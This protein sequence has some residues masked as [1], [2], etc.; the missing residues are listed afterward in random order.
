MYP[1]FISCLVCKPA[2][3]IQVAFGPGD[4]PS[5]QIKRYGSAKDG[6]GGK[7]S[8]S[9]PK[10]SDYGQNLLSLPSAANE[11]GREV[12]SA[13]SS[14]K[15]AQ[16]GKKEYREP[17]VRNLSLSVSLSRTR[18]LMSPMLLQDYQNTYYPS[19]L[20]LRRPHSGDPGMLLDASRNND[21]NCR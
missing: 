18:H 5:T 10:S 3:S 19:T 1:V 20:P 21:S 13:D 12:C 9:D 2:A 15:S 16:I 14:C 17:W 6:N 4:T 8:G 7:S 11:N